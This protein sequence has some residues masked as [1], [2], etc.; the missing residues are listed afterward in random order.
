MLNRAS[1]SQ[2]LALVSASTRMALRGV[3]TRLRVPLSE[4]YSECAVR[5]NSPFRETC[6]LF[7]VSRFGCFEYRCALFLTWPNSVFIYFES[8]IF[9]LRDTKLA[10]IPLSAYVVTTK[11]LEAHLQVRPEFLRCAAAYDYIVEVGHRTRA[12]DQNLVHDGLENGR[13]CA[14]AESE[15]AKPKQAFVCR[16]H[17]I[18]T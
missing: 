17:D 11:A 9:N 6:N 15:S 4:P 7:G 5:N 18:L 2:K 3:S 1:T 16:Q 13:R 8:E 14:K 10:F 12:V